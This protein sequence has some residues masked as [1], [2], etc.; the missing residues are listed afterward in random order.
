M[1]FTPQLPCKRDAVGTGRAT[2][3]A[4]FHAASVLITRVLE[5]TQRFMERPP[6]SILDA[7]CR[8]PYVAELPTPTGGAL[9]FEIAGTEW[10]TTGSPLLYLENTLDDNTQI[11][12]S[13]HSDIAS[14]GTY[15]VPNLDKHPKFLPTRNFQEARSRLPWSTC[16]QLS[17]SPRQKAAMSTEFGWRWRQWSS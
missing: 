8:F 9:G 10:P 2:L 14:N 3:C 6:P 15:S 12:S 7:A 13:L 1:C 11:V 4:A 17:R 5:D 16:Q